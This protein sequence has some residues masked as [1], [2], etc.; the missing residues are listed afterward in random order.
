MDKEA[1]ENGQ[2]NCLPILLLY[3]GRLRS[4]LTANLKELPKEGEI[5]PDPMKGLLGCTKFLG[6]M[7]YMKE[8]TGPH[9][10]PLDNEDKQDKE[11]KEILHLTK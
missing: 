10:I 11:D 5:K 7:N 9:D 8:E 6:K 2:S 3:V 1:T 4:R